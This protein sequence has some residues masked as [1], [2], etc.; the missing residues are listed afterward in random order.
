MSVVFPVTFAGPFLLLPFPLGLLAWRAAPSTTS[1]FLNVIFFLKNLLSFSMSTCFFF[2][3]FRA[4]TC[5]AF[6]AVSRLSSPTSSL[7]WPGLAG[8]GFSF[9]LPAAINGFVCVCLGILMILAA[10]P[11]FFFFGSTFFSGFD[12]S[13]TG[14]SRGAATPSSSFSRSTVV[15]SIFSRL[16]SSLSST[17]CSVAFSSDSCSSTILSFL[18][19]GSGE[20]TSPTFSSR[21]SS[22]ASRDSGAFLTNLR[23]RMTVAL[24][25]FSSTTRFCS[26]F[27]KS[28]SL[29]SVI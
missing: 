2:G 13:A 8:N 1:L 15:F 5:L 19:S 12:G 20:S 18:S 25:L 23:L 14:F 28:A 26:V 6:L 16:I 22:C 17:G 3:F 4:S 11:L 24:T 27:P 21:I 29:T 7:G 9:F 10:V